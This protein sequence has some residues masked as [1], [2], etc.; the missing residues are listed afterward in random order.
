M[1]NISLTNS[2]GS[3][4]SSPTPTTESALIKRLSPDSSLK[5]GMKQLRQSLGFS[6]N[7]VSSD[8]D[9]IVVFRFGLLLFSAI[10][11]RGLLRI[12]EISGSS[13]SAMI[14][15]LGFIIKMLTYGLN[16]FYLIYVAFCLM[17]F[18]NLS[19]DALFKY[20]YGVVML[21]FYTLIGCIDLCE[22]LLFV[23]LVI[24][25]IPY[26]ISQITSDPKDF[27]LKFGISQ[28]SIC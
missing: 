10:F 1:Y 6:S 16:I 24:L 2:N 27:F 9:I 4:L 7:N 13:E 8:E 3:E 18:I 28:V 20:P 12:C 14:K 21:A 15:F 25:S 19:N 5:S 17:T 26:Y 23:I 22:K 11:V